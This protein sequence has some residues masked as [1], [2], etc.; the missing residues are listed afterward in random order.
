[1]SNAHLETAIEAAWEARD[2]SSPATTGATRDAI[3]QTLG[4]RDSGTLRGAAVMTVPAPSV[5]PDCR[6][7]SVSIEP[8]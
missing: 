4:A 5:A 2:G 1:M 8:A 6:T 7:G 3:E